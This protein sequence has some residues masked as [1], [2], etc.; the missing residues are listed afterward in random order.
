MIPAWASAHASPLF[1][2]SYMAVEEQ[3]FHLSLCPIFRDRIKSGSMQLLTAVVKMEVEPA[4]NPFF[5]IST[6]RIHHVNSEISGVWLPLWTKSESK[7]RFGALAV[8][9]IEYGEYQIS[10]APEMNNP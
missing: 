3:P 7:I 4:K 6:T 8:M 9:N 2:P 5:L 10:F 1:L